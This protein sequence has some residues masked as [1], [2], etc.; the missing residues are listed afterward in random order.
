M[1]LHEFQ[2][3]RLFGEVGIPVPKSTLLTA[4]D[5][6]SGLSFP[7]ILKA[8]VPIG[9][10]GKAGGIKIARDRSQAESLAAELIG[11]DIR[12]YAVGA[13]LA[14][15]V[16]EILREIYVAVLFD[17]G[18]N[19]VMIVGSA[20]G[21]VDIEQVAKESPE[22]IV[23]KA[24]NPFMGL[25]QF[26]I[27]FVA[28]E[29]GIKDVAQ[30]G[31]IL[32]GMYQ[33]LRTHDATL[34]EINPLA[35]TPE[36]LLA[37]D[38]KMTL[39]GK[40]A[41]RHSTLFADLAGEH[42]ELEQAEST[43]AE[44]LAEERGITY[45]LLD[46]DVGLIADGAGTGMLTLDLI[47]DAGGRPANFCEMGGLANPEVMCQSIE[48]VLANSDV[49]ALLITLIGGLTRMDE[50]AEGI[51]QYAASHEATVPIIIRMAGTQEEVGKA[52][53]KQAGFRTF[54][55]L[56]AAVESVVELAKAGA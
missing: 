31:D 34:V 33:L 53:L 11:L 16:T 37:L 40:A 24:L 38:A 22:K 39:D 27:R 18:S 2:A 5:Q 26:A 12:G 7:V 19:Q 46:G 29:L 25:P 42:K 44:Q 51:V 50:M 30:F 49:K 43:L 15:A 47:Q 17:K 55:D 20:E 1:R 28:K 54:D 56:P 21:G 3:K 23:R 41:Y 10:R 52:T 13:L 9:G 6:V 45:V 4:P 8:Q 48:V 35:E 32:T 14:E 36:G